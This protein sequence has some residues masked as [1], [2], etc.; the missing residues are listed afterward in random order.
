LEELS[1]R[2][3]EAAIMKSLKQAILNSLKTNKK[4]ES[5]CKE[6]ENIKKNKMMQGTVAHTCNLSFSGDRDQKD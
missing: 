3:L 5:L 2:D 4:I 1:N 6:I